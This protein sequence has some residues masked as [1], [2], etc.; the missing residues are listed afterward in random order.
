MK[1]LVA[2]LEF[3]AKKHRD[4]RRK[5]HAASPY[6]N[7][8]IALVQILVGDANIQDE[9]VL[10][11]A[12]LHDTIE[13]TDT[14][15][16]EITEHF[17]EKISSIVLEVTDDVSLSRSERKALQIAH[18]PTLSPEAALV[19]L[20]DKIANLRDLSIA[21]PLNWSEKR[22][23][24]YCQWAKQVVERIP[25]PHPRLLTLFEEATQDFL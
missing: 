13:D 1:L 8:P 20:A 19:K 9:V 25:N 11:A 5:D 4:Q 10:A 21:P 3:A 14:T 15:A 12:L 16:E 24:D 18:A 2:A 23:N 6:I 17:G 7:H 22:K